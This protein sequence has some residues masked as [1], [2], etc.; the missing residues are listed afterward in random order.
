MILL[1]LTLH[2]NRILTRAPSLLQDDDD[3]DDGDAVGDADRFDPGALVILISIL[4][5]RF[6]YLY[7]VD[8]Q[9]SILNTR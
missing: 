3:D 5:V 8:T 7:S 2:T 4:L 1:M 6:D 9:Y